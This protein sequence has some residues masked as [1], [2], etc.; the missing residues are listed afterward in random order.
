[1]AARGTWSRGHIGCGSCL[2]GN[3]RHLCEEAF[4]KRLGLWLFDML[5]C[6]SNELA[7]SFR[8]NQRSGEKEYEREK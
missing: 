1:M 8:E 3:A 7:T 5:V 6:Q 4:H 2:F